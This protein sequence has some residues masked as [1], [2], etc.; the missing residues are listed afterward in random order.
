MLLHALKD[1]PTSRAVLSK[2]GWSTSF[3]SK[4]YDQCIDWLEEMMRILDK[5]AMADL[6][7]IL[8]NYWNN[9]NNHIFRGKE[10]EAQQIWERASNLN[11]EFR[12]CN[13]VNKPLLSNNTGEKKWKMPPKGFIKINFDATVG[14]NRIGYGTILRDEEGFVLGGG[15]GFKELRLSVEEAECMAFEESIN[16]ARSLNLKE[17]VLFKTDI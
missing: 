2:G 6:I 8:W 3:I 1:Y 5:R 16:V 13:M 10:E 12:I 17:H 15:G 4:N 14:E 7:T 11:K 9:R